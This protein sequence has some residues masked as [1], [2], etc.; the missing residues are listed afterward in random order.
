MKKVYST[1]RRGFTLIET[2]V[3]VTILTIG[4]IGPLS[5][6][7]R[8]I[9]D[10]LFAQNQLTA[11]LLAQEALETIT[12]LRNSNIDNL[13][14]IPGND[15]FYLIWDDTQA[16]GDEIKTVGVDPV[17]GKIFYNCNDGPASSPAGCYLKSDPNDP[18]RRFYLRDTSPTPSGQFF[19]Q[20]TL[21]RPNTT[22]D[23]NE[24]KVEVTIK[25][26]NKA[27]AKSFTISEN[28]YGK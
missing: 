3:A 21:Y 5:L 12:N 2:L 9:S 18:D 4:V 6:A 11:N 23:N 19:R 27:A 13:L 16:S 25:W 10:G 20:I 15:S 8:G 24:M 22:D 26:N 7:A 1:S 28:L 14:N 17:S